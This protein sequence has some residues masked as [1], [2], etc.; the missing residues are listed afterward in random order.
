MTRKQIEDLQDRLTIAS[1]KL[2]D[3][4][5]AINRRLNDIK[6]QIY[7]DAYWQDVGEEATPQDEF[8]A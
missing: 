1:Y 3:E 8:D 7:E 6:Y 2:L 4:V 5:K